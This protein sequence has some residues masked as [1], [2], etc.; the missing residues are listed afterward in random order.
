[1]LNTCKKEIITLP[2]L[3]LVDSLNQNLQNKSEKLFLL[4]MLSSDL[5]VRVWHSFSIKESF[6]LFSIRRFSEWLS[7]AISTYLSK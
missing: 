2:P 3:Y 1:M 6:Y 4:P 5:F 7:T